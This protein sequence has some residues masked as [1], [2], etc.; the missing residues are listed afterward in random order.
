[1]G[2]VTYPPL[3][4]TRVGETALECKTHSTEP[5]ITIAYSLRRFKPTQTHNNF[6][7][8]LGIDEQATL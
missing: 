5:R 1:M 8:T 3:D 4:A 6:V 2:I 7:I